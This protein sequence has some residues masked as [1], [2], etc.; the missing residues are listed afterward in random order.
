MQLDSDRSLIV[1]AVLQGQIDADYLLDSDLVDLQLRTME[2]IADE[3]LA[4]GYMV[5]SDD[6]VVHW[7][8]KHLTN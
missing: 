7:L 1:R 5:F 6:P 8:P 2:L 3:M 4:R